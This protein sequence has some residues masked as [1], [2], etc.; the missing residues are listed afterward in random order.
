MQQRQFTTEDRTDQ[1]L[2]I[3][4]ANP[5]AHEG[6]LELAQ[7]AEVDVSRLTP[8]TEVSHTFGARRGGYLYVID[9]AVELDGDE[10]L[11]AGDALAVSDVVDG[12]RSISLRAVEEAELILVDV[13][14]EWEP[15]GRW[16]GRI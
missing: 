6:A 4:S 2:R 8:G 14:L 13:P 1:W 3:M 16:R 11:Q 12:E 5:A 9:G 7:D 15:V 10:K